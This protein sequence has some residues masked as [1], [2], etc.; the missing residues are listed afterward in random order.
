MS[1]SDLLLLFQTH[2]L[3]QR[4]DVGSRLAF[5]VILLSLKKQL[6][7]LATQPKASCYSQFKSNQS[8]IAP[9]QTEKSISASRKVIR[10]VHQVFIQLFVSIIT[11][12]V[13]I[14]DY[15]YG[16]C[17]LDHFTSFS[18]DFVGFMYHAST[19]ICVPNVRLV[20]TED[21]IGC[22]CPGIWFTELGAN[23]RMLGI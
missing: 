11:Q 14:C 5:S 23:I 21:R 15:K 6:R 3:G 7:Q 22:G 17:L 8:Q 4:V 1:E 20:T 2:F 12:S 16:L 10:A 13:A 9:S 19:F 18:K